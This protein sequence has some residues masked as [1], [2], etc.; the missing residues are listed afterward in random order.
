MC[1]APNLPAYDPSL[2]TNSF[3]FFL[4]NAWRSNYPQAAEYGLDPNDF[5]TE[6][7]FLDVISVAEQE[8]IKRRFSKPPP[9]WRTSCADGKPYGV[10][11]EYYK[12]EEGYNAAL[13]KAK[14][15]WRENCEDGFEYGLSPEDYETEE[16]YL[17]V[18]E[19]Y[20]EAFVVSF[21]RD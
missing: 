11:L 12:T 10:N 19:K 7:E 5:E 16:E 14:Y 4:E 9:A 17:T 21:P 6:S 20:R 18:W 1:C 3:I 2:W 13:R 15:G 8:E